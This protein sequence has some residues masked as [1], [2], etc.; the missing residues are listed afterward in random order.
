[1]GKNKQ[2]NKEKSLKHVEQLAF[3]KLLMKK[4]LSFYSG[5]GGG[6][7][8]E[9][10]RG[11]GRAWGRGA[12]VKASKKATKEESWKMLDCYWCDVTA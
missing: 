7:G 3:A 12:V 8:W 6:G 11:K 5:G 1:M 4:S 9:R 2:T 10:M